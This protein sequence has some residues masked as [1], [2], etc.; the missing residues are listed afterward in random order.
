MN[1][2]DDRF[3][4]MGNFHTYS[5]NRKLCFQA[6]DSLFDCVDAQENGNKF[7]CPDQL[8]AYEMWCPPD[9]R[10]MHSHKRRKA[11]IDEQMYDPEWVDQ[12]NRDK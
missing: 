9:F 5:F 6:R 1:L 8:Y 12:V 7:R 3:Y 2:S 4:T 11:K 10:R